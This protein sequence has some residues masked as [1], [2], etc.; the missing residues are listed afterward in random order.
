MEKMNTLFRKVMAIIFLL[1]AFMP[2]KAQTTLTFIGK[3][4]NGQPVQLDSVRVTNLSRGWTE[5]LDASDLTLSMTN[6]GVNQHET[7]TVLTQNVPNPF[8][9][10][11]DFSV[12]LK[13]SEKVN[14][15]VFTLAGEKVAAFSRKLDVGNH[16]FRI[17]NMTFLCVSHQ[18][19]K[20]KTRREKRKT[21]LAYTE[22]QYNASSKKWEASF[23]LPQDAPDGRYMLDL[24]VID[25]GFNTFSKSY[26]DQYFIYKSPDVVDYGMMGFIDDCFSAFLVYDV[27]LVYDAFHVHYAFLVLRKIGCF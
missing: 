20:A 8:C 21:S 16:T 7:Q 2:I 23:V 14:V 26:P 4:D 12:H 13:R 5:V 11:T 24:F 27:F 1:M 18:D 17:Q 22:M 3:D 6:S 25:D 15:A 10:V 9:G 19:D